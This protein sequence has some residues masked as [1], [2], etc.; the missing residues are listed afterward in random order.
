MEIGGENNMKKIYTKPMVI[1]EHFSLMTNI[2]AGC[3]LDTP[4]PS[5]EAA[6]GYP[7]RGGIV[8]V[9]GTECT[10]VPQDGMYNGF[11]YHNPGDNNNLFNS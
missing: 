3:E 4:L 9:E 11:C 6:C 8:F 2:A 7:T 1:V 10:S 5:S